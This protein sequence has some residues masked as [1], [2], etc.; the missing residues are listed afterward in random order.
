VPVGNGK[1]YTL[2]NTNF[3]GSRLRAEALRAQ[4][5]VMLRHEK[6]RRN[7]GKG[8]DMGEEFW[9]ICEIFNL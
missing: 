5:W 2:E 6:L 3:H 7:A 1:H 8:I 9:Y 4:A